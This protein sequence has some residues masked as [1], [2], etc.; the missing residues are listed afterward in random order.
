MRSIHITEINN[1]LHILS[2]SKNST[3]AFSV[4]IKIDISLYI[5]HELQ[6]SIELMVVV[7]ILKLFFVRYAQTS[8]GMKPSIILN[9][10]YTLSFL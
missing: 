2:S 6:L 4:S 8:V 7:A 1:F 10:S 9:L 5:L 3:A